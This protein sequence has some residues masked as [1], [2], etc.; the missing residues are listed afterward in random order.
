MYKN[1]LVPI[2]V[3]EKELTDMVTPH[4]ESLAKLE[5][6]RIH[7]LA[8]IPAFPYG[9]FESGLSVADLEKRLIDSTKKEL[10]EIIRK[11]SLPEDRADR[12]I[13]IGRPKDKILER[14]EAISADLII[15]GSR[16]PSISTYL[17][18]S[19]AAAVVR[20]AKTSVLVVR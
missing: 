17:L 2:D 14:A 11:F 12:Y 20:Y 18:G 6:A 10:D 5:D 7:F 4:V 13:V 3:W 8:V 9:G 15:I 16:R 19:T 1:I